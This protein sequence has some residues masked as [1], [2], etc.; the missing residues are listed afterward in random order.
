MLSAGTGLDDIIATS[1]HIA[2]SLFD[3]PKSALMLG[4]G[5]WE[6]D[7]IEIWS[8][9]MIEVEKNEGEFDKMEGVRKKELKK[10]KQKCK[11]L[12]LVMEFC[13]S[14]TFLISR[15]NWIL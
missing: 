7:M 8:F 9:K 4:E 15:E 6:S 13:G 14:L 3:K 12:C 11:V 5:G 10:E 2:R 1:S